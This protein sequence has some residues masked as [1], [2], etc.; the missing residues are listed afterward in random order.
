ME[1][2]EQRIRIKEKFDEIRKYDFASNPFR[3][4]SF[5]K[6]L[7]ILVKKLHDKSAKEEIKINCTD[8]LM[9]LNNT[10]TNEI[11]TMHDAYRSMTK[12]GAAKSKTEEYKYAVDEAILH[13]HSDIYSLLP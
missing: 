11:V 2:Q 3:L 6:Q 4:E 12:R 7:M 9:R 13:V 10:L 8:C 1:E 5:V